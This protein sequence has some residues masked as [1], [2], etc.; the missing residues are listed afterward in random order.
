MLDLK[1]KKALEALRIYAPYDFWIFCNHMDHEFFQRR[2][3]LKQCAIHIQNLYD[4]KIK[5]LSISLPPRAGKSYLASMAA[6]YFL[7]RRPE[8]SVMRN[9]ATATLY[10]K[11]SYDVRD[12]IKNPKFQAAFPDVV[13]SSDKTAV[14]GWNLKQS[15]QVSYFGAGTGGTIIGFGANAVAITD[16]L[17]KGHEDALSETINEKVHRWHE[18]AHMSRLEKGCVEL[19]IGT[20]WHKADVIGARMERG[21]YDVSVSIP[22]MDENDNSFCEDVQTTEHYKELRS[23]TDE[24]IWDSEYMQNPIDK[25]GLLFPADALSYYEEKNENKGY[26][27]AFIDTADA[28]E[29]YFAMPIVDYYHEDKQGYLVDV[30]FNKDVLGVNH[31]KVLAVCEE[32]QIDQLVIET[33]KEGGYFINQ[34]RREM[35]TPIYGQFNSTNKVTRIMAQSAWIT[36]NIKFDKNKNGQYQRFM[37]NLTTFLRTGTSKNDDAP[38]SLSGLARYLRMKF[39]I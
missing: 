21:D 37:Q 23:I 10:N 27:L 34:L 29:D 26:R 13:L 15:K 7:G 6:A 19:D 39:R 14:T 3:F 16:D 20:R 32:M 31:N 22:A 1:D 35:K 38:D 11:F 12:I 24:F 4:Q 36:Q 28:G 2:P 30:I 17:Y 18:S 9:S 8:S 25:E 5:R 33:N